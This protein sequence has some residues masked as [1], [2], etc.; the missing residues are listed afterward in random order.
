V[1][2]GRQVASPGAD[3]DIVVADSL[4]LLS[5]VADQAQLTVLARMAGYGVAHGDFCR[6]IGKLADKKDPE[7]VVRLAAAAER[8]FDELGG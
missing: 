1:I 5:A 6:E 2:H 8:L 3:N 7:R 4:E